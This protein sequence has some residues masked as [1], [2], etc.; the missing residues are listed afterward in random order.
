MF[1]LILTILFE[2]AAITLMKV[3]NGSANKIAL[4]V[5]GF[6]YLLSFFT[7]T[8]ALKHLPMGWTNAVWAGTS[9]VIVFAIGYLFFDEQATFWKIVFVGCIVVGLVGLNLLEK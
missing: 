5:G 1:Y 6:F 4:S 3:A 2:S 9:A 8:K 7:L